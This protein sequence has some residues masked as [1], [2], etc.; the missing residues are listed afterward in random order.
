MALMGN[1]LVERRLS[2]LI[3]ETS[4][5]WLLTVAISAA[6]QCSFTFVIMLTAIYN[7]KGIVP[8]FKSDF[9]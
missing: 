2:W 4:C 9:Q 8:V 1:L 3:K 7:G 5:M 6:C